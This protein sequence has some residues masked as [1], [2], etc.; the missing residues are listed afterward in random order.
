MRLN[1][2]GKAAGTATTGAFLLA[3]CASPSTPAAQSSSDAA[4]QK[5]VA[6]KYV[7]SQAELIKSRHAQALESGVASEQQLAILASGEI[8]WEDYENSMNATMQCLTEADIQVTSP[9]TEESG[10]T[11]R[12]AFTFM[13]GTTT[14]TDA[15]IDRHYEA[16]EEKHS[17]FVSTHWEIYSA[18]AWEYRD[19]RAQALWEPFAECLTDSGVD[20]PKDASFDELTDLNTFAFAEGVEDCYSKIGAYDW[21]EPTEAHQ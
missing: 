10:G 20:V 12:I 5:H 16:C 18:D 13:R 14:L 9:Y 11:T 2:L 3:G 15:E 17:Q 6:T 19:R 8:T 7:P 21:A 1:K 4:K